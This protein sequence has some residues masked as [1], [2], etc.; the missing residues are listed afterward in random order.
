MDYYFELTI[1]QI[2]KYRLLRINYELLVDWQMS[3]D[4]L[5]CSPMFHGNPRYD[6][7][8]YHATAGKQIFGQLHL[9]FTCMVDGTLYPLALM[10]PF[11]VPLSSNNLG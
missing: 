1:T 4:I 8:L 10:E 3:G 9:I 2:T 11:D 7:I 6:C 5:R